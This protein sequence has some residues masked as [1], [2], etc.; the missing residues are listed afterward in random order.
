MT[1]PPDPVAFRQSL[2]RLLETPPANEDQLLATLAR[3]TKRGVPV[4][5]ALLSILSHLDFTEKK[6][7][8][9][10]T[11]VVAHRQRLASK[12]GRDVGL[13]V[14]LLDYLVNVSRELKNPKVIEI[15]IYES[16][17]RSAVTDGLTGLANHMHFRQTARR[18]LIRSKRYRLPMSLVL[19]D[20]DN[21]KRVNDTFGHLG[22]DRFLVKMAALARE[23]L[24]EI[25]TAARYGGEEFAFV[26]PDTPRT[27]GFV[28]AE[29][30]RARVEA[31]H[32]RRK[33]QSTTTL[34]GGI[35]TFPEDGSDVETLLA[36]ADEAL[37]RAKAAGKNRIA[38]ASGE[39]RRHHRATLACRARV[40]ANGGR[41][42]AG[43]L[44]N[45]SETGLLV[46][47][48]RPLPLGGPVTVEIHPPFGE[49]LRLDGIVARAQRDSA[50]ARAV[51]VGIDMGALGSPVPLQR[52]LT[53]THPG[54]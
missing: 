3:E 13:R 39:R 49:L 5:S 22:G 37:Y 41:A 32:R 34:S 50:T 46:S 43:Q 2:L 42:L 18:E 19:V 23:S 30:V 35:A 31:H 29:R 48:S 52:L 4:Y 53:A 16:T 36:R 8:R 17:E 45:V 10:W 9:H 28:V 27:G 51:A 6:A 11:R 21:F 33:G 7:R 1:R 15:S 44:R 12:L 47:L 38:L 26:L 24:R 54:C 25:D 14:A 40:S 20:L